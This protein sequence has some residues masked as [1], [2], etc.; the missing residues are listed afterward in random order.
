MFEFF[1][2]M[3]DEAEKEREMYSTM[4]NTMRANLRYTKSSRRV[5]ENFEDFMR[6]AQAAE[7]EQGKAPVKS[8]SMSVVANPP[9][10]SQPRALPAGKST[11]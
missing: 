6:M 10:S 11:R 5:N 2:A 7:T 4:R 8:K 9:P 1:R 3:D